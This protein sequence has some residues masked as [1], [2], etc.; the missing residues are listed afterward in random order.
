MES[1]LAHLGL[2]LFLRSKQQIKAMVALALCAIVI[3]GG[4]GRRKRRKDFCNW[5]LCDLEVVCRL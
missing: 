2:M 1:T 3:G 5:L 4:G